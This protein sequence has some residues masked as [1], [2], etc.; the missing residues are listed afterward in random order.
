MNGK[1]V[2]TF[3]GQTELLRCTSRRCEVVTTSMAYKL[4][5]RIAPCELAIKTDSHGTICS[6]NLLGLAESHRV[7]GKIITTF[8]G[9]TELL[10]CTSRRCEVVTI[11]MAYKLSLRIAP[12]ELAIKTDSHGTICSDNLLGLAESHRV[13][14]K[15][16]TT[17]VGQTELLRCTSRR[18]E[19]VTTSMAYK[20]SLRIAPCEL[21]IKTDSH[22]TICSNNLLGLAESHRVK[23]KIITTFVGQTELLPCTSRRCEVVTT[24]MAYK[25][26]LH[27]APCELALSLIKRYTVSESFTNK[28]K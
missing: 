3:V 13:K 22:R 4:S 23:G 6:D 28:N 24:S 11:S 12:C 15:I 27:I 26:S 2:S 19:V 21:A 1:I 25:L 14:G 10:R 20:L 16:I 8:V 17:F 9:Q 5:L 18:C 7:K